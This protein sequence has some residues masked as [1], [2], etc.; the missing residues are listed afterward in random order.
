MLR[1]SLLL[2]LLLCAA[3]SHAVVPSP[4]VGTWTEVGGSGMARIGA[5]AQTPAA[6]CATGLGRNAAGQVV[7]TGIV[8]SNVRPNGANRWRGTYHHGK[9]RLSATL[10]LM[11]AGKVRMKVCMLLLCQTAIYARSK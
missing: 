3:K 2:L 1:L 7:E 9:Q 4:L 5:C 11:G 6:L 10:N 8:L